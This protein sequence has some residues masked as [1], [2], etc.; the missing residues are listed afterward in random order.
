M[1]KKIPELTRGLADQ[2]ALTSKIQLRTSTQYKNARMRQIGESE[3]LYF[4]IVKK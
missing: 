3:D 1:E 4:G 2:I